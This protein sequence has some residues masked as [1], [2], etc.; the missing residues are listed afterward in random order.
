MLEGLA[1]ELMV[2]VLSKNF[3]DQEEYPMTSVLER[4]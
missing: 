1:H 4:R 2:E 3:I